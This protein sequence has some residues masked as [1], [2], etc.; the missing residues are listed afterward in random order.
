LQILLIALA[1][2]AGALSRYGLSTLVSN[3]SGDKFAFGTLAVNV[4][5]CF[6]I[7]F[8][9]YIA[10]TTNIISA[11]MKMVVTVGFL[12]AL[13]T[14]STFSMETYKYIE[15]SQWLHAGSNIALNVIL[16]LVATIIGLAVARLI[17]PSS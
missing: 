15:N 13:T 1:G 6:L 7:G 10:Q 12:G 2:S 14:F 11:G 16:G 3:I 8:V 17:V 4:L 5:G 9:I